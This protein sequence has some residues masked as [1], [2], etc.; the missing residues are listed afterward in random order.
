MV[1]GKSTKFSQ[2]KRMW[3]QRQLP[4]HTKTQKKLFKNIN[5]IMKKEGKSMKQRKRKKSKTKTWIINS[6]RQFS[7]FRHFYEQINF[8]TS[9]TSLLL[10]SRQIDEMKTKKIIKKSKCY[11]ISKMKFNVHTHKSSSRKYIKSKI[12]EWDELKMIGKNEERKRKRIWNQ[13]QKGNR[14]WTDCNCL[15]MTNETK[16]SQIIMNDTNE[17][18]FI[19]IGPIASN[20]FAVHFN[21]F[22]TFWNLF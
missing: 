5:K 11:T 13:A 16:D 17:T 6:C 18:I 21:E 1:N 10:R 4:N 15:Q 9:Y 14:K 7:V 22:T 12:F 19:Y 20:V 8:S 3:Q 2:N